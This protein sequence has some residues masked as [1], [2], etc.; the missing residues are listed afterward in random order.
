M[1]KSRLILLKNANE[2]QKKGEYK[3]AIEAF[4]QLSKNEHKSIYQKSIEYSELKLKRQKI[5][6]KPSICICSSGVQGPTIAGGIGTAMTNLAIAFSNL[7]V[8]VTILYGGHPHYAR[9][10]YLYW[11]DKFWNLYKIKFDIFEKAKYYGTDEMIRSYEAY[12][13]IKKHSFETAIFHDY[14]GLGFFSALAKKNGLID[15]TKIIINGHGNMELSYSF[16][17]KIKKTAKEYVIKEMEARSIE[18]ADCF[19]S[20]SQNYINFW[21][22]LTSL[23]ESCLKIPNINYENTTKELLADFHKVQKI[24]STEDKNTNQFYF[25]SRLEKLKGLD[26]YIELAIKMSNTSSKKPFFW[27]YGN[28]VSID[29]TKSEEYISKSLESH[30]VNYKVVL[31]PTPS[32]FFY[33]IKKNNGVLIFPSL[34]ENSPCTVVEA[35]QNKCP[36]IASDIPGVLE[37]LDDKSIYNCTFHTGELDSL[38]NKASKKIFTTPQLRYENYELEEKWKKIIFDDKI[39]PKSTLVKNTKISVIIPTIGRTKY[40]KETLNHFKSQTYPPYEILV[41]DNGSNTP[42]QIKKLTLDYN[43]KYIREDQGFKGGACNK[44]AQYSNG[45]IIVFFD[46]D[47][48]PKNN[49]LELISYAFHK[50]DFD[51]ISTFADVFENFESQKTKPSQT[52]ISM[53]LGGGGVNFFSNYFGKG[54]F[55]IRRKSFEKTGGFEIDRENLPLVDYRFYLKSFINSLKIGVL[56]EP[57]YYYRKNSPDS[58]YNKTLDNTKVIKVKDKIYNLLAGASNPHL[59]A[60]LRFTVDNLMPPLV[61]EFNQPQNTTTPE[62]TNKTWLNKSV[63][64]IKLK[65][66]T[67][68][69]KKYQIDLWASS[70]EH[71]ATI[72]INSDRE[73]IYINRFSEKHNELGKIFHIDCEQKVYIEFIVNNHRLNINTNKIENYLD[74]SDCKHRNIRKL[75]MSPG[76]EIVK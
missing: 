27:F 48:L 4:K 19:V 50:S 26:L 60:A 23:P 47:D 14:H 64:K 8:E 68:A 58:L 59:S 76:I 11:K 33:D 7:D 49:Y 69:N 28:S 18:Y 32:Q 20:P 73:E 45:E 34:G 12:Q 57:L 41:V 56:P 31:N 55:A 16:G 66:H 43:V 13:Y 44:G 65:I 63:N 72:E 74:L 5:V 75:I 22:N 17:S 37:L 2:L 42:E 35:C 3:Q 40:L 54:C 70:L 6:K 67:E 15:K 29:G 10:D 46:D 38:F 21:S 36:L 51:I 52:Y 71:I 1:E 25:Y 30:N 53:A 61:K 62:K 9:K 39:T 24:D